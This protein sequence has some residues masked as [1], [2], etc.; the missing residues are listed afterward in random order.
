[1]GDK[2][3]NDATVPESFFGATLTCHICRSFHCRK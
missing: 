2:V 1:M 3:G